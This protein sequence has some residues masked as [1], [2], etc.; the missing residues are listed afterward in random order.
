VRRRGARTIAAAMRP[1]NG[2][3]SPRACR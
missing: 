1:I 2:G 3:L